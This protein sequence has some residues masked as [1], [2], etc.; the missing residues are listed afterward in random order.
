M[1]KVT[2]QELE[3]VNGVTS[4]VQGQ[5]DAKLPLAGGTLTGDL[6]LDNQKAVKFREQ[7]GNG[8]NFIALEAPDSVASDVTF[9]LP[10]ADGTAG[11]V[12]KTNGSASL[13]WGMDI[14]TGRQA[15]ATS[16]NSNGNNFIGVTD[17]SDFRTITLDTDDLNRGSAGNVWVVVIKDEGG[18]AG[19]KA[20]TIDTEGTEKIDGVDSVQI[21]VNYGCVRFYSNGAAWFSF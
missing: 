8:T 21:T 16:V 7:S 20:I 17:T 18:N 13:S 4:G 12:L 2:P 6:L 10:A 11:Q 9:K 14:G 1:A 15:T 3:Y 19:T 5:L